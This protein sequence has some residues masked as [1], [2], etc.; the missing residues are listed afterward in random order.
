MEVVLHSNMAL[1]KFHLEEWD[2]VLS[3]ASQ[4]LKHDPGNVKALFR[5]AQVF[6]KRDLLDK[7]RETLQ[8]ILESQPRNKEALVLMKELNEKTGKYQSR[9][10]QVFKAMFS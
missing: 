7:T 10:K 3:H 5:R 6:F 9:S 2:E 8:E 1:M 4:V